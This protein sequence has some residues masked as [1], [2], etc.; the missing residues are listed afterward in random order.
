MGAFAAWPVTGPRAPPELRPA[1]TPP[2]DR[3]W[4]VKARGGWLLLVR[5]LGAAVAAGED[6]VT[7]AAAGAGAEALSELDAPEDAGVLDAPGEPLT[8]CTC[9]DPPEDEG[10]SPAEGCLPV[11]GCFPAPR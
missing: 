7:A 6:G 8:T 5:I 10:C 4:R 3:T 11:E 9:N 2:P 1:L